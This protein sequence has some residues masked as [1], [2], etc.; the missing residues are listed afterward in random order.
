MNQLH[1]QDLFR[2]IFLQCKFDL[3]TTPD[4]L[5]VSLICTSWHGWWIF[6]ELLQVFTL[7]TLCRF[8]PSRWRGLKC[9]PKVFFIIIKL[10][11]WG[12]TFIFKRSLIQ[13]AF[14]DKFV[15]DDS[16][17]SDNRVT[18][19]Y[20][21][22]S[23]WE[24]KVSSAGSNITSK[25]EEF[26]IIFSSKSQNFIAYDFAL[27]RKSSWWV[28]WY[29]KSH[30][31]RCINLW[32]SFSDSVSSKWYCYLITGLAWWRHARWPLVWW[33]PNIFVEAFLSFVWFKRI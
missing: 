5:P 4:R 9:L 19:S 11:V 7:K 29:G 30:C 23:D 22:I 12:Q 8:D 6:G 14:E 13:K 1:Q 28:Y 10:L 2:A 18:I 20:N 24:Y 31:A 25:S 27:H 15:E 33:S 26:Q 32:E 21:V 17:T 3:K 16:N